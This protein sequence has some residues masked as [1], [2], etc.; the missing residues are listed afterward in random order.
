MSNVSH[1]VFANVK[2]L[3]PNIGR[4][5]TVGVGAILLIALMGWGVHSLYQATSAGSVAETD[6]NASTA[7]EPVRKAAAA[8]PVQN[9]SSAK[10]AAPVRDPKRLQSTGPKVPSL[11]ID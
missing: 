10:T 3:P 2:H 5:V 6:G 9:E 8:K 1:G 11:Y 4:M 7:A